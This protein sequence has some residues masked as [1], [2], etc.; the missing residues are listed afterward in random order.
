MILTRVD[1][2][3]NIDSDY[4]GVRLSGRVTAQNG[5]ININAFIYLDNA[6]PI[7]SVSYIY[8]GNT[9]CT[10]SISNLERQYIETVEQLLENTL[11]FLI[12]EFSTSE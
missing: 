3:Y 6:S 7:G 11:T 10:K 9:Q 1:T 2:V 4:Q 5:E 8:R 12:N